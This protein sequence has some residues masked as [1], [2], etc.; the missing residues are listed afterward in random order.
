MF[1]DRFEDTF[2]RLVC[3][4]V[5]QRNINRVS[6][7]LA[8]SPVFL[9]SSPREVFSKFMKTTGHHPI[10]CIKRFFH[11]ISMMANDIDI[12]DARLG[13]KELENGKVNIMDVVE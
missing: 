1:T 11:T 6:L 9:S 10:C 3:N 4:P 13:S 12:Q 5:L 7:A 2:E 8:S